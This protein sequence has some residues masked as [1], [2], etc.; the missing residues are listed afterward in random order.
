[1]KFTR[2]RKILA[3]KLLELG[4]EKPRLA[5][6]PPSGDILN[7][8]AYG[9]S[10]KLLCVEKGEDFK[11]GK[12]VDTE[13]SLRLLA[14]T[15]NEK[16]DALISRRGKPLNLELPKYPKIA[17][18]FTLSGLL[19]NHELKSL[20]VQTSMAFSVVRNFFTPEN[21]VLIGNNQVSNE[22]LK[23]YSI[24]TAILENVEPDSVIV[25]DPQGEKEFSHEEVSHDTV[26]VIGGIVDKSQ[27][28][29]GITAK[30]FP[31]S[32]HRKITL[33][34][35]TEIVPDRIN[36]IA[37]IVCEYLTSE[38]TLEEVV[39]KNLTRDSKLRWL[40]SAL[41]RNLIRIICGNRKL[42]VIPLSLWNE[43]KEKYGLNEFLLKKSSGHVGGICV[44]KDSLLEK[45]KGKVKKGKREFLL[46]ENIREEE[47]VV[48]YEQ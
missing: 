3:E 25:L 14:F 28:L 48:C 36:E 17:V 34:G 9:I 29:E 47:I 8:I 12:V 6:N 38:S 23:K 27:R 2:P 46:V 43:W 26:I 37:K 13:G 5:F 42:R 19:E 31:D 45:V 20:F 35:E 44:V 39:V 41:Q 22:F 30:I 15:G 10:K 24:K 1:M 11:S 33:N 21:F 7:R 18:D 40:R 32:R 16:P 4:I